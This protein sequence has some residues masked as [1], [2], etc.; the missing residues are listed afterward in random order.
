MNK[1]KDLSGEQFGL[2]TVIRRSG[3]FPHGDA[4]WLCRCAC[5]TEK[6]VNSATLKSGSSKSC[7]C[8][9]HKTITHGMHKTRT[10][11][12]WVCMKS[13]CNDENNPSY[14]NYGG[15][16]ISVCKRW[17]KFENFLED[18]GEVPD[19]YSLERI[20]VNIGYAAANCKWIPLGRQNDNK[21]NTVLHE[22]LNSREL[23]S[24]YDLT[25]TAVWCR[26]KRNTPLD[27]PLRRVNR[28]PLK[29]TLGNELS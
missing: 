1:I 18:M 13:R 15:R 19:G 11:K 17:E 12:S 21:R 26:L 5:G 9:K 6:P 8:I 29:R 28:L 2:W 16:G 20:D 14:K 7:G 10:Y 3:T 22:G 27:K 25:T 24:K 4:G 23:A